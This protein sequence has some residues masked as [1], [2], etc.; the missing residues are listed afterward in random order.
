M[1]WVNG[2]GQ[3]G[4]TVKV[5][6]NWIIRFWV[7]YF[8]SYSKSLLWT[9]LGWQLRQNLWCNCAQLFIGYVQRVSQ[10][11]VFIKILEGQLYW[12]FQTWCR[13]DVAMSYK[14]N[15]PAEILFLMKMRKKWNSLYIT[16]GELSTITSQLLAELTTDLRNSIIRIF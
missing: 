8:W 2:K 12:F 7:M 14:K 1:I 6:A 5:W 13:I 11:V 3:E 4:L 16:N 15:T 9:S 10:N